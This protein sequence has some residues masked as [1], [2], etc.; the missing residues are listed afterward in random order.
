MEVFIS[1]S[2][3]RS[4]AVAQL[5]TDWLPRVLQ[6]VNPW[7]STEID[8]GTRW[9][10]EV[11]GRLEVSRA[12]IICLTPDNLTSPWLHFEAGA[13]AKL[14]GDRPFTFLVDLEPTD[15][16]P[17]LSQFQHT[18]AEKND[19]KRL[20]QSLNRFT[21]PDTDGAVR[22]DVLDDTFEKW[23]PDFEEGLGNVP[24]ASTPAAAEIRSDRDLLEEILALARRTGGANQEVLDGLREYSIELRGL[25]HPLFLARVQV[26]LRMLFGGRIVDYRSFELA[27]DRLGVR[28]RSPDHVGEASIR[29]LLTKHEIE[30]V[31]VSSVPAS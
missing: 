29:N 21:E 22:A 8:K 10:E 26:Q 28:F 19:F 20:V 13:I 5:L 31:S 3:E 23:W 1:W 27:P 17:P 15:I 25:D 12:G 16:G 18:R 24:K 9:F 2:G 11:S 7:I 30:V 6:K 14:T 4:H